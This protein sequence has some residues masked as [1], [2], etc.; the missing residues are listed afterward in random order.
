[1]KSLFRDLPRAMGQGVV[2][3]LLFFPILY[4]PMAYLFSQSYMIVWLIVLI[5]GYAGGFAASR[6]FRLNTYFKLAFWACVIG[7]LVTMSLF[8]LSLALF[9][10]VPSFITAFYRGGRMEHISW[11]TLFPGHYYL[12]GLIAYGGSSF[13]LSFAPSFDPYFSILTVAGALA[14]IV[15]LFIVNRNSVEEQSIPGSEGPVIERRVLQQNRGMI[16]ALLLIIGVIVLIPQ[17]QQW[18]SALG[19][20]IASW[21]AGLFNSTPEVHE[22]PRENL[23][24]V[25]NLPFSEEAASPP[26][27]MEFIE[28]LALYVFYMIVTVLILFLL[29]RF[30]RSLPNLLRKISVWMNRLMSRSPN[31]EAL[32]GYVD[33]ETEIEHEKA[34]H[35]FKRLL[36]RVRGSESSE[37]NG[38][39]DHNAAR[40]RKLYRKILIRKIQQG[41]QWNKSRTPRETGQDLKAWGK[42]EEP[43]SEK[44]IHLYE[45]A[46]YGHRTITDEEMQDSLKELK[47]Q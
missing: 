31:N 30:A 15:T 8:G 42:A 25:G 16:V 22:P 39:P 27:W 37:R 41:Y 47:H 4:I 20:M 2:E 44:F 46:R 7:V 45:Q 10:A 12:I 40:I 19:K 14:L 3:C 1:M 38:E 11:Y 33:E 13:V 34:I 21:F 36:N 5:F 43:M 26:A 24:E 28:Q 17:L 23:P 35:R 6:L 9:V 29:Y 18:L 32:L